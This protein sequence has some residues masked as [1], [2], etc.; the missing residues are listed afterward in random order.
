VN[1]GAAHNLIDGKS[2]NPDKYNQT[3]VLNTAEQW[4]VLNQAPDKAHP[5]HIHINPFQITEVFAP[6]AENTTDPSG[7]CYIDPLR[8][9]T[10]KPCSAIEAPFVWWDT[11]AIPTSKQYDVTDQCKGQ[12]TSG[13]PEQ[14]RRFVACPVPTSGPTVCT[15]TIP[16]HFKMRS[17]FV[18]FPGTYV[19]HCHILI[20]EDR[21][22]MQLVR[23]VNSLKGL[24]TKP[25]YSHH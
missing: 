9:A 22:M 19:L 17:R 16:G 23:V 3:M 11:F 7:R 12:K 15:L 6:N 5:F 4:K 2:F 20:H 8:P 18:D 10:W 13:C 1:F 25:P 24:P 21:G 14:I